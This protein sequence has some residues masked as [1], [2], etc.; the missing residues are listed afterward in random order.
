[1]ENVLICEFH[2]LGLSFQEDEKLLRPDSFFFFF[3]LVVV[4][5]VGRGILFGHIKKIL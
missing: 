5:G 2:P 1:M 3:L 4:E